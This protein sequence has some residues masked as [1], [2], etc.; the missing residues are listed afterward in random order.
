M[1][2]RHPT[3]LFF[4]FASFCK[5]AF[6]L[7]PVR[8]GK[9]KLM[10]LLCA[11][12]GAKPVLSQEAPSKRAAASRRVEEDVSPIVE[13]LIDR[14][15][16]TSLDRE[17]LFRESGNETKMV[18]AMRRLETELPGDVLD[19]D[20]EA[21]E[22]A[23]LLKRYVG[24][25]DSALFSADVRQL[26]VVAIAARLEPLM[27]SV[28]DLLADVDRH[29]AD[30]LMPADKVARIFAAIFVPAPDSGG[31]VAAIR[32][33]EGDL[34]PFIV[35]FEGLIAL[36]KG[37]VRRPSPTRFPPDVEECDEIDMAL[38]DDDLYHDDDDD[39]P[40]DVHFMADAAPQVDNDD[41]LLRRQSYSS[42][43]GCSC[44]GAI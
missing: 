39:L 15:R 23:N 11:C 25:C 38:D 37:A 22:W 16:E 9:K 17:G 3:A 24:K 34:N 7:F 44:V 10:P 42:F 14:L 12:Q 40:D 35:K 30:N 43:L 27:L 41:E 36:R 19:D 28:L 8:S 20:L 4:A 6:H 13:W 32:Y 2:S 18:R 29:S 26:E 5:G 21:H 1:E 31:P 33:I